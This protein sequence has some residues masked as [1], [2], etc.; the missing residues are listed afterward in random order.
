MARE[1]G[2]HAAELEREKPA[3]IALITTELA[4]LAR[5]LPIFARAAPVWVLRK[6][7]G[8]YALDQLIH[9]PRLLEI[10]DVE[11][12]APVA[13]VW[14]AVRHGHL[15]RS[16]LTRALFALREL[17]RRLAGEPPEKSTLKI[18][19]LISTP[20][21]PG[22]QLLV[23]MPVRELAVGAIGKV[24]Q[25]Q[26]PFVHVADAHAFATFAEPGFIKVA[27]AVQV[28]TIRSGSTRLAIE[29]R[30]DGTDDEAWHAFE[31]YFRLIGPASR[32]IRKSALAQIA[33]EL[34]TRADEQ[35]PAL[36][37]DEFIAHADADFDHEIA[38][39]ATPAEIWPWLV[40]MGSERAGFYSI[41]VLDNAGERSARELHAE[42][43]KLAVGD[44]I[45][46]RPDRSAY[47]EVL[48][49]ERPYALVLGALFDVGR[50][51][52]VRFNQAPE[53]YWRVTWSFVLQPESAGITRVRVRARAAFDGSSA[54]RATWMRPIHDVMESAQLR[55]LRDRV[56]HRLAKDDAG[57]V[58][59]GLAGA[60]RIAFE[61]L[62]PFGRER[63]IHWGMDAGEAEQE[64]PG[65]EFVPEPRWSWTHAIA[66]H[67]GAEQVWPWV[68]QI[69][70]DRAGFY[71]YQWLE[72][73]VGCDVRNAETVHPE[74][75][76]KI[77]DDFFVHPHAPPLRVTAVEPGR[78][79]VAHGAADPHAREQGKAWVSV[80]WLFFVERKGSARCRVIS[81]Y[82]ASH[83]DDLATRLSF[84]PA[85][86]RPIGFAMDRRMLEGIRQRAE[87][88]A[89]RARISGPNV[90]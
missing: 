69:G 16:P 26:I 59:E 5:I 71:S 18:D 70:A 64:F 7:A 34:D 29:L 13:V 77:G 23:E 28:E 12:A 37:G 27:W 54:L 63:Q 46:S 60:A 49:L 73:I 30:V 43:Q 85:L 90:H 42:W 84:G 17:P 80:S 10:D 56:E 38:I 35:R 11:I 78:W 79:F 61:L 51:E 47:F 44:T 9:A 3:R 75:E 41:D 65:D 2:P 25:P 15:A 55:H 52:Q 31:R 45:F 86:L 58:R 40:Q 4:R 88:A 19:D 6:R 82:R 83:S 87:R 81:R 20:D 57:D 14:E 68:A 48:R 36:P 21:K 89:A 74:W 39:H 53:H 67:A 76:V 22:F 32:F 72:N 1:R 66:V 62:T 24:W 50:N 8:M 33:R